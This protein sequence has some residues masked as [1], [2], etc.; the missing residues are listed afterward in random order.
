MWKPIFPRS[1]QPVRLPSGRG[2]PARKFFAGQVAQN[3]IEELNESIG[4][5]YFQDGFRRWVRGIWGW[6]VC[7][8]AVWT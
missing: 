1:H 2:Q 3:A 6:L 4:V 8:T 5:R 7:V